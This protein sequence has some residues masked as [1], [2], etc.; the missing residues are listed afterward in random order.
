MESVLLDAAGH[1]RSSATM[2]G[3]HR[4]RPTRVTTV[5]STPPNAVTTPL[6]LLDHWNILSAGGRVARG[7]YARLPGVGSPRP[8]EA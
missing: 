2:P 7:T 4:S 1:R 8:A 3:Y 5:S 6:R